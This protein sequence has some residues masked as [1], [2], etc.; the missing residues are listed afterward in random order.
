MQKLESKQP[1]SDVG[2]NYAPKCVYVYEFQQHPKRA[3]RS[4]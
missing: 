4:E 2:A 3:Y 1:V